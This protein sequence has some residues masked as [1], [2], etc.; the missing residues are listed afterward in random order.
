MRLCTPTPI[1]FLRG[2]SV[3]LQKLEAARIDG[4]C[5]FKIFLVIVLPLI[6]SV[7]ISLTVFT[8]LTTWDDFLWP[9]VSIASD[10]NRTVTLAVAQ[11]HGSFKTQYGMVMAGTTIAFAVPFLV[12]VILQ[13]HFVEGVTAS[14]V[15]G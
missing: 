4:A 3:A 8:F 7:L 12:Y 5:D 11:L 2:R 14:G 6:R 9:L 1:N 15:K 10:Q 13:R